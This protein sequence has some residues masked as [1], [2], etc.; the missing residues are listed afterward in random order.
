ML[1]DTDRH[2]GK[3]VAT[4]KMVLLFIQMVLRRRKGDS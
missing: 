2:Q 1:T 4:E 3:E